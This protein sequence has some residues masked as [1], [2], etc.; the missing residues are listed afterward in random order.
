MTQH[1][2]WIGF[3]WQE[4]TAIL[5]RIVSALYYT[6]R[7]SG[8]GNRINF[9]FWILDY[10]RN[11]AGLTRV[12]SA[13]SPWLKRPPATAHL[14]PPGTAYW[15]DARSVPNMI[16]GAYVIFAGGTEAGLLDCI[17][18]GQSY[19]RI[20]DPKGV[21]LNQLHAA[22]IAGAE[23]GAAGFWEAQTALCTLIQL[24]HQVIPLKNGTD[25]TIGP[26]TTSTATP[27]VK[28]VDAF[29]ASRVGGN[30]SLAEISE[31]LHVSQSTLSHR[32]TA[33][34]GH[35][36][37]SSFNFMRLEAARSLI[38]R[39]LKLEAVA[40]QT[41]FCDA[42]HLSKAFTQRF[43]FPPATYRRRIKAGIPS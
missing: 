37:L 34:A 39:G 12:G 3:T 33:E 16:A 13:K 22:A 42:Y 15:E 14:Y 19:A 8:V 35:S 29:L 7:N 28:E 21:I 17:P 40:A 26:V 23:K 5:P 2:Q 38:L 18:K 41:G 32:Y 4:P 43:S 9:P 10:S 31:A 6:N 20:S 24:L 11:Y 27:F 30:V 1:P 36:P 25:Q